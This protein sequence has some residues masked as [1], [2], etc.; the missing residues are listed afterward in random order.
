M[1]ST[2]FA[3]LVGERH[4]RSLPATEQGAADQDAPE[5]GQ[6]RPN[7]A[8]RLAEHG[9]GDERLAGQR[10]PRGVFSRAFAAVLRLTDEVHRRAASGEDTARLIRWIAEWLAARPP[11]AK[12][13]RRP[14]CRTIKTH[15]RERRR[16]ARRRDASSPPQFTATPAGVVSV[17]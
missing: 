17:A 2:Q 1:L 6:H 5:V 3:D 15:R 9:R 14:R 16:V 4:E 13:P 8:V 10:R 12:R 7:R 11:V